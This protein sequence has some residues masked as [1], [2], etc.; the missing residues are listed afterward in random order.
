M[1]FFYFSFF[2]SPSLCL[3]LK[4]TLKFPQTFFQ[5]IGVKNVKRILKNSNKIMVAC[6]VWLDLPLK[7]RVDKYVY[8]QDYVS[9]SY[10]LLSVFFS[11]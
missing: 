10:T 6:L 2:V 9:I 11:V 4:E 1:E 5:G 3:L 7:Y 8:Q